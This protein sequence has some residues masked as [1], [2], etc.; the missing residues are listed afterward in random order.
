[1]VFLYVWHYYIYYS[2]TKGM[3]QKI[4]DILDNLKIEYTNYEH[5]AVFTCD[6]AK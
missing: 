2:K 1:M 5:D 3:R 6:E 4:F